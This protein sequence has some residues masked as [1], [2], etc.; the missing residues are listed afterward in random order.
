MLTL[1]LA[2]MMACG[3]DRPPEA[4]RPLD[5]VVVVV[6][7]LRADALGVNGSPFPATP[8]LDRLAREEAAS[9]SRAYTCA[10]WTL[11]SV[12]CLLTGLPVSV[13]YTHLTLPTNREV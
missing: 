12:A 6:D 9:F 10:T 11:P 2:L 5:V 7:T 3:A 1:L 13:S 4:P 8:N